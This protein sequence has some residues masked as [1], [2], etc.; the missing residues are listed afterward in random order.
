VGE[1][2]FEEEL[3]EKRLVSITSLLDHLHLLDDP[4]MEYTLLC[5]CFSLQKFEYNLP[6]VDTSSHHLVLERFD[7]AVRGALEAI[8]G[9][10]LTLAQ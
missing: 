2:D 4:H 10:P 9:T 6:T 8:L 1:E 5:H 7:T 3:L